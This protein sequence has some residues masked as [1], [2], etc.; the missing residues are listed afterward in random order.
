M[1][2]MQIFTNVE[3]GN[4]RNIWENNKPLFCG[5]DVAKALGYTNSSKAIND[6][7]KSLQQRRTNDSLG[8]QQE[9]IFIHEGDVYRLIARSKL[10]TA[11]KFEAWIFEEILPSIRKH[12]LYATPDKIEALLEDPDSMIKIIEALKAERAEKQAAQQKL[13]AKITRLDES[14]HWYTIKRVAKLNRISSHELDYRLL[15]KASVSMG[16]EIKKADDQNYGSVNLYHIDVWLHVY[17]DLKYEQT[18]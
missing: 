8:R 2:E 18:V 9:M 16:H 4:I 5:F 6:H 10:P 14:Q 11:E 3:F 1:S 15:I 17:G 12:G 13:D 7:C